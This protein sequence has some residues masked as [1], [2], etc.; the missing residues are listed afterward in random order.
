MDG[1]QG[2]Q[3]ALRVVQARLPCLV[4]VYR[5]DVGEEQAEGGKAD[6]HDQADGRDRTTRTVEEQAAHR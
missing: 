2:G 6:E 4:I 3:R 5:L 1:G